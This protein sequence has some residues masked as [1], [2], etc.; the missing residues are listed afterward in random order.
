MSNIYQLGK[1]VETENNIVTSV[2]KD[3]VGSKILKLNYVKKH[4]TVE[5]SEEV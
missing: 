5:T 3:V 2:W 1:S 4:Q